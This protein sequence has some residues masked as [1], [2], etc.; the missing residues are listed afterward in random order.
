VG[1]GRKNTTIN[2][3]HAAGRRRGVG[4]LPAVLAVLSLLVFFGLLLVV[5]QQMIRTAVQPSTPAAGGAPPS[6]GGEASPAK[7]NE[8]MTRERAGEATAALVSAKVDTR[9]ALVS[10]KVDTCDDERVLV[11]RSHTLPPDYVPEDLV[12]LPGTGVPTLGGRE[13]LL[14][15]EA[16]WHLR[17]LVSAAAAD[18]EELVVASAFRSYADQQ[19]SH[20]RLKSI[21]GAGADAMSATPGHSQHQLGTAVDFTNAAAAYQVKRRFGYTSASAWL[22]ENATEHGFVLAYPPGGDESGYG[23]EPWHYRYVGTHDAERLERSGLSL[24]G[25]LQRQGVLPKC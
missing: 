13:M 8:D 12:S 24:Q 16:A 1:S 6:D 5:E 17:D 22:L 3:L 20:A 9:A 14:R 23:W 21:Y 18:G 4:R 25:F 19:V 11:D 10:A 7:G 15:R 2:L